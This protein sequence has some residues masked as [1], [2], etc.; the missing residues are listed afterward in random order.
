MAEELDYVPMPD[1]TTG[2]HSQE[3]ILVRLLSA[4]GLLFI[5]SYDSSTEGGAVSIFK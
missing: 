4:L 5:G 1:V 2:F 3:C